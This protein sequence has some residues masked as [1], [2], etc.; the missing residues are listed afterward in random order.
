M[1]EH[2]NWWESEGFEVDESTKAQALMPQQE[3]LMKLFAVRLKNIL[4]NK[5]TSVKLYC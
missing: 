2:M 4:F 1:S 3:S 5:Y